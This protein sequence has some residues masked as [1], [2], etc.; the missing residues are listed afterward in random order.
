MHLQLPKNRRKLI[1]TA[2]VPYSVVDIID[3]EKLLAQG[4]LTEALNR[5]DAVLKSGAE[6]KEKR[7]AFLVWKIILLSELGRIAEGMHLAEHLINAMESEPD[8]NDLYLT[9]LLYKAQLLFRLGRIPQGIKTLN[10]AWNLWKQEKKDQYPQFFACKN[11]WIGMYYKIK[12]NLA[13][14]VGDYKTA[15]E[16]YMKGEQFLRGQKCRFLR[17]QLTSNIGLSYLM[18]GELSKAEKKFQDALKLANS[19]RNNPSKGLSLVN[20]SSIYLSQG[21]EK[22]AMQTLEHALDLFSS[23]E[24]FGI[25]LYQIY[26][27]IK[28]SLTVGERES[29]LQYIQHL[30]Y[31]TSKRDTPDEL[32]GMFLLGKARYHMSCGQMDCS[33]KAQQL[34]EQAQKLNL[35][36]QNWLEVRILLLELLVLEAKIFPEDEIIQQAS[37]IV[38][39][40]E[41]FAK[42][43]D[44]HALLCNTHLAQGQL[45]LMLG[46]VKNAKKRFLGGAFIAQE[47]KLKDLEKRLSEHLAI[48][49]K[50]GQTKHQDRDSRL[51]LLQEFSASISNFANLNIPR[52]TGFE[53]EK[54]FMFLILQEAGVLTYSYDFWSLEENKL[55]LGAFLASINL[56]AKGVFL[57]KAAFQLIRHK[58]YSIL[59]HQNNDLLYVY[60][61]QG[62]TEHARK[63]LKRIIDE[64]RSRDI[65][66]SYLTR[67]MFR[68]QHRFDE[69]IQMILL[70]EVF[71]IESIK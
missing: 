18:R 57:S 60:I 8:N 71:R 12:G 6:N 25:P 28:V 32:K 7:L 39:E 13:S 31:F 58:Q 34:L 11:A 10:S 40:L 69:E 36:K 61:F 24:D 15:Q 59:I 62:P 37:T 21:K 29:A 67:S 22:K 9:I 23:V 54:P 42:S 17:F 51:Y 38:S 70:R 33:S 64:I 49:N 4:K 53:R 48:A 43:S 2:E 56:F 27:M 55:L 52:G 44:L 45:D 1:I 47:L 16:L 5:A 46:K 68:P 35:S 14:Y 50:M 65:L 26:E 30:E 41:K 3:I 20:L 63:V 19:L 66:I